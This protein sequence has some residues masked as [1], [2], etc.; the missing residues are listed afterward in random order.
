MILFEYA[1]LPFIQDEVGA[2]WRHH[3]FQV[4]KKSTNA[5]IVN[6]RAYNCQISI[7]CSGLMKY[8]RDTS[9]I[10]NNGAFMKP[11]AMIMIGICFPEKT[12]TH[13]YR[14]LSANINKINGKAISHPA[15]SFGK[16]Q[17]VMVTKRMSVLI[18][19]LNRFKSAGNNH[20]RHPDSSHRPI[21]KILI[22]K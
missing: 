2:V 1:D 12:Q 11:C 16:C 19:K 8:V 13:E 9:S 6:A 20:P 22:K 5:R 21:R 7:N 10:K 17:L 4:L 15:K 3:R 18:P 14:K